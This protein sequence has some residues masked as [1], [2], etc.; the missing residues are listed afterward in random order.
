M[1]N[2]ANIVGSMQL[3]VLTKGLPRDMREKL[4]TNDIANTSQWFEVV[5]KI[6]SFREENYFQDK[7]FA[8]NNSKR[9]EPTPGRVSTIQDKKNLDKI[10]SRAPVDHQDKKGRR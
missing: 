10:A 2:N 6:H 5:R 1:I 7:R 9:Q 4:L 3:E 8:N